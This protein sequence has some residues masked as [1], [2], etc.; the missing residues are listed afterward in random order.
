M[1]PGSRKGACR[2]HSAQKEQLRQDVP[3]EAVNR[4]IHVSSEVEGLCRGRIV[5]LRSHED[6]TILQAYYVFLS[7]LYIILYT[8]IYNMLYMLTRTCCP[9]CGFLPRK[10]GQSKS[11]R[12]TTSFGSAFAHSHCSI[13]DVLRCPPSLPGTRLNIFAA[14]A[15]SWSSNP[16]CTSYVIYADISCYIA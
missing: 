9:G 6:N 2:A 14:F 12:A 3:Q 1:L 13:V 8:I 15:S 11:K 10:R 16:A 4:Q 5:W 7:L